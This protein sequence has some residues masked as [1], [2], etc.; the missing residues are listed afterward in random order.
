MAPRTRMTPE[1]VKSTVDARRA[2]FKERTG[3]TL[4]DDERYQA[5]RRALRGQKD[6]LTELM[7]RL[8]AREQ[9]LR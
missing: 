5:R 6:G 3:I 8:I 7:Q 9:R 4:V 1:Q 2:A